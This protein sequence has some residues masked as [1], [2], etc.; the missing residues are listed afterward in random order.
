[1]LELLR[2]ELAETMMLT[3]QPR[4]ELINRRALVEPVAGGQLAGAG[5]MGGAAW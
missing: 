4:L 3:G 1:V 5:S 2:E